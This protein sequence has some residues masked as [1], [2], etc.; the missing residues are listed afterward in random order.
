MKSDIW[1]KE[2]DPTESSNLTFTH[3]LPHSLPYP[4]PVKNKAKGFKKNFMSMGKTRD[5]ATN[6]WKLENRWIIKC[7]KVFQLT[8]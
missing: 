6:F 7:N 2:S 5:T 4:A 3:T 1:V 8:G